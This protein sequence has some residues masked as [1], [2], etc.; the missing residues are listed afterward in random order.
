VALRYGAVERVPFLG[1]GAAVPREIILVVIDQ[2]VAEAFPW[3][4][5]ETVIPIAVDSDEGHDESVNRAGLSHSNHLS[6]PVKRDIAVQRDVAKLPGR[7]TTGFH[8]DGDVTPRLIG[9]DYVVVR[10]VAGERGR[11]E[12]TARKFR[13]DE[14]L[15]GLPDKL[16]ATSCC[17]FLRAPT[18]G[19]AATCRNH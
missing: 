2:Q 11:D 14:V 13:R 15:A 9:R 7:T 6:F 16:V 4:D 19:S 10:D 12:S 17:H 8:L 18:P 3:E 1:S 5:V